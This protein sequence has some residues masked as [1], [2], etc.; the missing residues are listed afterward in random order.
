MSCLLFAYDVIL[1]AIN[2]E[3]LQSMVTE[4][5]ALC[6]RK[7]M[8]LDAEKVRLLN[9]LNFENGSIKCPAEWREIGRRTHLVPGR[10]T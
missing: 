9:C 3:Y 2:E 10:G 5:G 8:K 1:M 4:M 6:G 7:K